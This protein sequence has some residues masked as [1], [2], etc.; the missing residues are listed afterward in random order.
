MRFKKKLRKKGDVSDNVY[1]IMNIALVAIVIFLLNLGLGSTTKSYA[2][3]QGLEYYLLNE[4]ILNSLWYTEPIS[5]AVQQGI[6]DISDFNGETINK[7]IVIEKSTREFGIRILLQYNNNEKEI[8]FNEENYD[9]FRIFRTA[10]IKKSIQVKDG[11]E[12]Y[13]GTIE[14]EQAIKTRGLIQLED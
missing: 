7:T 6:I 4:R 10:T 12:Y 3:T 5:Q 8:Y 2:N 11:E 13:K 9:T 1:W 14:V